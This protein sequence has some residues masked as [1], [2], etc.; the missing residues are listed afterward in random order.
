MTTKAQ[1]WQE[2]FSALV[3]DEMEAKNF[4]SAELE[5]A[6]QEG[7]EEVIAD[8]KEADQALRKMG[9]ANDVLL[10]QIIILED[11]FLTPK[12]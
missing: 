8:I 2:I 4:I 11:K 3:P 5:K 10:T 1:T 9:L 12:P 7:R 6:K